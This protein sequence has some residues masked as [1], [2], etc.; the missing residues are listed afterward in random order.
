MAVPIRWASWSIAICAA[1]LMRVVACLDVSTCTSRVLKFIVTQFSMYFYKIRTLDPIVHR[2]RVVNSD[3]LRS[4]PAAVINC[5]CRRWEFFDR[6]HNHCHLGARPLLSGTIQ[7]QSAET[8]AD[9]SD[10]GS[11]PERQLTAEACN[12]FS[13]YRFQ[14][15]IQAI[16]RPLFDRLD[17]HHQ[18][19]RWSHSSR[20][21]QRLLS[22][23][24]VQLT[25]LSGVCWKPMK[26][27]RP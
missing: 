12:M 5:R 11:N 19:D 16:P 22:M 3:H 21:W 7:R 14:A 2:A 25:R 26:A 20:Y 4:I 23:I 8:V 13:I 15:L 9:P 24:F 27:L 1:R 10:L 18:T 17:A 6:R